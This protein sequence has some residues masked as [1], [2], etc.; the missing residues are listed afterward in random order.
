[1]TFFLFIGDESE[2]LK[3]IWKWS[4]F[5]SFQLPKMK[6]KISENARFLY[7]V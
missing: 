2:I 5:G 1:M 3:K 6:G 4:D 7:L